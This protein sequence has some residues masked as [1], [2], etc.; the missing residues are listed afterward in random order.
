MR[1]RGGLKAGCVIATG[2]F[3]SF[4]IMEPDREVLGEFE[5]FGEV[6]AVIESGGR[7]R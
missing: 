5:G 6:K 1:T 7:R 3:T 2:S 4:R